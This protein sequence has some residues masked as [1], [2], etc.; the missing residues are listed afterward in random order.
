MAVS[1]GPGEVGSG[2]SV[3]KISYQ[4]FASLVVV[5]WSALVTLLLW[6]STGDKF[7]NGEEA[8]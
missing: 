8:R 5:A 6:I 2:A 3:A 1:D 4:T 7:S